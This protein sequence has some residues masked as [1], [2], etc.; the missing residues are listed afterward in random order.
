MSQPEGFVKKGKEKLL[1]KLNKSIY[2]LMQSPRCWNAVLDNF[3]KLEGFTQPSADQ[4]IYLKSVKNV[5]TI[6]AIYVDDL[7]FMS[8]SESALLQVKQRLA[9]RFAM[10]DL[11]RL[12][13]LL[14]MS[15]EHGGDFLKISQQAFIKQI[16]TKFGMKTVI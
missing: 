14:G 13:F 1:G 7:V 6:T 3:L 5:K 4:C 12:H 16:L 9:K 8:S 15:I 10:K 2:G 11:G